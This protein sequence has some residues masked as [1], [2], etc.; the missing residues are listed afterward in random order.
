[1]KLYLKKFSIRT[2]IYLIIVIF[3]LLII[4]PFAWM[5][6]TSF[7]T[8]MQ[9]YSV[10][11]EFWPNPFTIEGYI[12]A[13]KTW[14]ISRAFINTIIVT[15]SVV[16]G[17]TSICTLAGYSF[18]KLRFPG[19][20]FWFF[21][22]LISIMLPFQVRMLPT[23]LLLKNFGWLNTYQG[24]IVPWLATGFAIFLM[25]QIA[26]SI[27]KELIDAAR[28][29]GCS[30]FR[31]F[32]NIA[33]PLIKPGV[34]ALGIINFLAI[35]NDLIG[36]LVVVSK[37]EYKTLSLFIASIS[38]GSSQAGALNWPMSMAAVTIVIIPI[39]VAYIFAQ[40]HIIKAMSLQ[41][42]IK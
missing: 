1:M 40:R 20:N 25:R 4:I 5:I 9:S 36:P 42:G 23:F 18:A 35:W 17:N 33:L 19:K 2:F 15:V 32:L 16:I 21:Y 7:K 28:I 31:F 34:Y 13:F 24:L 41:S 12:Q 29:D 3:S 22:I 11:L 8:P 38:G 39:I 6:L 14:D 26:A 10:P 30:E 27:P 37:R